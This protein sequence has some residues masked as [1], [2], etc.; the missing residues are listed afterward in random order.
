MPLHEIGQFILHAAVIGII[1]G[2]V[3]LALWVWSGLKS[4]DPDCPICG[5]QDWKKFRT[6]AFWQCKSCRVLY[7]PIEGKAHEM[8]WEEGH[9]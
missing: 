5:A 4:Y 7:T 9:D 3:L 1:G 2:T 6:A 8:S